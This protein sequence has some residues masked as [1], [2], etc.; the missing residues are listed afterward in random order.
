MG[1]GLG[2]FFFNFI[3]VA[4]VNPDNE[5]QDRGLFPEGVGENMP[6]ALQIMAI[7]YAV[8]G[9]VGAALISPPL[10]KD[11]QFLP[12]VNP[13]KEELSEG[14]YSRQALKLAYD[15]KTAPIQTRCSC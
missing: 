11:E 1:F 13:E 8:I 12:L 14:H 4:L 7:I 5:K 2:A 15:S 9:I 10:S 6:F 3:V